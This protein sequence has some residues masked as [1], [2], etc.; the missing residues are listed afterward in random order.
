M[1]RIVFSHRIL[2]KEK[3]LPKDIE[4][5]VKV[6]EKDIFTKIKGENL[7]S[8][9]SLIKIYITTIEGAQRLVLILD[10]KINVGHFLLYRKKDDSVGKNISLKNPEFRKILKQYLNLWNEDME[11]D[12]FEIIELSK[13]P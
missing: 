8:E 6:C 12:N 5:I 11:K 13:R 4:V 2:K 10:E 3:L 9:S 1:K 7:L